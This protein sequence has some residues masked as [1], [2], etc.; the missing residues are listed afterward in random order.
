VRI[1]I[2]LES[3]VMRRASE[4]F[5][6]NALGSHKHWIRLSLS[7]SR[8]LTAAVQMNS[9]YEFRFKD[10]FEDPT[11]CFLYDSICMGDIGLLLGRVAQ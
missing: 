5:D 1:L 6:A 4:R 7:C 3:R 10:G 2:L 8:V 9:G 11:N